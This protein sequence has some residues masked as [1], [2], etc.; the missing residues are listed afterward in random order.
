MKSSSFPLAAAL[1]V[2][3]VPAAHGTVRAPTSAY[4]RT[5]DPIEFVTIDVK[6]TDAR[7]AVSPSSAPR[8]NYARFLVRNA[9]KKIHTFTL[10]R[11]TATGTNLQRGFTLTVKPRHQKILL[12]YL[13]YRGKL[14]Y[15]TNI[16]AG[17]NRSGANGIFTIS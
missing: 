14:P 15:H 8:G 10:G 17:L 7:I 2:A 1:A 16:K 3:F 13:D 9:G 6:I 12:L 11:R 4:P 5:T